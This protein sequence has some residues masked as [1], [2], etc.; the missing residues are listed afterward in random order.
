MKAAYSISMAVAAGV[1]ISAGAPVQRHIVALAGSSKAD[2][3]NWQLAATSIGFE[4][5][6]S[7]EF[8]TSPRTEVVSLNEKG[9]DGASSA[10]LETGAGFD[11]IRKFSTAHQLN[12][13]APRIAG[14]V[15]STPPVVGTI[16]EA[17]NALPKTCKTL[18]E[19]KS[20]THSSSLK[21]KPDSN[22]GESFRVGPESIMNLADPLQNSGPV[23]F[24]STSPEVPK[25][26]SIQVP[27]SSSTLTD[28]PDASGGHA[29]VMAPHVPSLAC[30]AATSQSAAGERTELSV[31]NDSAQGIP[32]SVRTQTSD[33]QLPQNSSQTTAA[34]EDLPMHTV[35]TTSGMIPDDAT[36]VK[37]SHQ[38]R[39]DNENC[40]QPG[41]SVSSRDLHASVENAKS[42]FHKVGSHRATEESA[43]AGPGSLNSVPSQQFGLGNLHEPP[44]LRSEIGVKAESAP[45]Q[46]SVSPQS[47]SAGLKDP[48]EA[49]DANTE[50]SAPAWLHAGARQ[51]EAGF[52]DPTLGWVGVRAHVDASGVHAA[53][54]PSSVEAAQLLGVHLAGLNA[55]L[56]DHHSQL[57]NVTLARPDTAWTGP[58]MQQDMNERQ[59]QGANDG[60]PQS[61]EREGEKET[62]AGIRSGQSSL[63]RVA[64]VLRSQGQMVHPGGTHISLIA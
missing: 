33:T 64:D 54:V 43:H 15:A 25:G 58:Q 46:H 35:T 53:L 21:N 26:A 41:G 40:N 2:E 18:I 31:R 8:E 49:M 17:A 28:S 7:G 62:Q 56:A 47:A 59:G 9:T 13:R 52:R 16:E 29:P 24:S 34:A 3:A 5:D 48:L 45:A 38:L 36:R 42:Q 57:D 10:Q 1:E 30:E 55:Y 6:Q 50:R 61:A 63:S 20:A 4:T 12:T 23:A 51:A 27:V 22:R 19:K 14:S 37:E 39:R 11:L 44:I 60:A 32:A